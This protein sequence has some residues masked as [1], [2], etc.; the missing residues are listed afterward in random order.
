MRL[1]RRE[2]EEPGMLEALE[3]A[4]EYWQLGKV[5]EYT[6]DCNKAFR[7]QIKGLIRGERHIYTSEV[8]CPLL[9]CRSTTRR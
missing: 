5:K 7:Y 8:S 9:T 3:M 6:E 4:N 1:E 2:A